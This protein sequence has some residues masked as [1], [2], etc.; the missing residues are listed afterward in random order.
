MPQKPALNQES[1]VST[2][3]KTL[4]FIV[5]AVVAFGGGYYSASSGY[6]VVN[7]DGNS[8]VKSNAA[9]IVKEE[10][11]RLGREVVGKTVE[12]AENHLVKNNRTMFVGIRNGDPVVD[13]SRQKTFTNLTVEV[14]GSH[15][16]RVLGWY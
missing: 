9:Q 11:S 3:L 6:R 2:F 14:K 12:D 4:A 15:V 8:V 13:N 5:V 16:I 10:N 1:G 7:S